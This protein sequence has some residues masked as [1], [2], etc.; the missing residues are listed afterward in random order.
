MEKFKV[1]ILTGEKVPT[2]FPSQVGEIMVVPNPGVKYLGVIIEMKMSRRQGSSCNA[3]RLLAPFLLYDS[4]LWAGP[5]VRK[6][7]AMDLRNY[8]GEKFRELHPSTPPFRDQQ[9]W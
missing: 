6:Y 7:I 3:C 2:V 4:E 8:N 9:Q 1:V 5:P